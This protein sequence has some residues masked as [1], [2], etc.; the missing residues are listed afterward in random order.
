[1]KAKFFVFIFAVLL[2]FPKFAHAAIL[3]SQDFD[4]T[5]TG[6]YTY[7]RLVEDFITD[8][9]GFFTLDYEDGVTEGRVSIVDDATAYDGKS[10]MIKALDGVLGCSSGAA[11]W[12][13]FINDDYDDLYMSFNIKMK[14]GIDWA[15]GGKLGG[16]CGGDCAFSPAQAAEGLK[17]SARL[18]WT[19]GA[20]SD[21][22]KSVVRMYMYHMN[23]P[24]EYGD[25]HELDLI[26]PHTYIYAGVWHHFEMR[27]KHNTIGNADGLLQ[28]WWDDVLVLDDSDWEWRSADTVHIDQVLFQYFWGGSAEYH[29]P[30]QDEF[31]YYDNF[32]ISTHRVTGLDITSA[33]PSGTGIGLDTDLNWTNPT[34]TVTVDVY[35]E[36][37]AGACDLQV[38]D[39]V[40]D[41]GD[42]A[43]Y[44][45]GT[46]TIS[47]SYCWRVDVNHAGGTETGTVY[48]FTTTGGPPAPP[49]GLST[50]SYHSL[51]MTGSYAAQGST[52]GE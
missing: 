47:T 21:A 28:V 26:A 12:D 32:I 6:T 5:T 10:I 52:V 24:G 20:L 17:W 19:G 13:C 34:G 48:E 18:V 46:M 42:V 44:E 43:T 14:A 38:G 31:A 50:A 37:V 41:D 49:T 9:G 27:V 45:P 3:F 23:M 2:I 36:E 29:K 51:G 22:E 33:S 35:F 30:S 11:C 15:Y 1:M 40:V 25:A 16:I 7:A 8:S 4:D 39:L